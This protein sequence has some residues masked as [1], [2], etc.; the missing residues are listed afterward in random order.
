M[1]LN[2]RD[3]ETSIDTQLKNL[4][5]V[6][7]LNNPN[8]NVYKQ[9]VKTE[10]QKRALSGKRP[11]F[12]L[13]KDNST[14]PLIVIEAKRPNENIHKALEQGIDYANRIKAPIVF[15]TDGIFTKTLHVAKQKPLYLNKEELDDLIRQSI[16]INYIHD[17]EYNTLDK[18]VIQSREELIKIFGRINDKFREA[19]IESG[20]PRTIL[21]C[22]LLFLKIITELAGTNTLIKELPDWCTWDKIKEKRGEELRSFINGQAFNH[23][24]SAY[25]GDVLS[26][27]QQLVKPDILDTIVRELDDLH[28]SAT[29]TDI[30]GDAFEYF[31]RN[32]GGADT[33]FGEYFTPR[34]ITKVLIKLLNPQQGEKLYDPFC[35]T[36]GLLITGYKHIYERMARNEQNIKQLKESTIYG[37]ELSNMYRIAKMNMILAGDGH[38]NIV[39]QDSYLTPQASKY[40]VVA[41]NMPF[42]KKDKTEGAKLYG[43]NTKS[44]EV[45]G[46]LHCLNALSNAENARAGIIVPEGILF[47]GDKAYTDL[48][49]KITEQHSIETIVSLP[50]MVFAPYTNTKTDILIIKKHKN[51]NKNH[52]WYFDV[53]NDGFSLD[54]ARRKLDGSND[55]DNLLSEQD[56]KEEDKERLASLGFSVLYKDELKDN[57][58][59][60]KPKQDFSL[61]ANTQWPMVA[62]GDIC[63]IRK[64]KTITKVKA[65][66]NGSVQVIAGGTN[67]PYNHDI[68]NQEEPCITISASG[69][70]GYVWYHNYPIWAS[71]CWVLTS[72]QDVNIIFVYYALKHIQEDIYKLKRGATIPHVYESDLVHVTIPLPPLEEQEKIVK[73]LEAI[74][75]S[76]NN[77]KNLIQSLREQGGGYYQDYGKESSLVRLGDLEIEYIKGTAPKYGDSNIQVIKSG[78][79]R[80]LSG[81]NFSNEYFLD[82]S[83][84]TPKLLKEGDI[85][86]N[87]TGVGTAGRITYFTLDGNYV[88][89]S[90][91]TCIRLKEDSNVLPKYLHIALTN[92]YSRE[93]LEALCTGATGQIELNKD[94]ILNLEISLPIL[95]QQQAIVEQ[96]EIEET[97]INQTK[98][99]IEYLQDKI[100][101]LIATLW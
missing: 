58:Y 78:Q 84:K 36:G 101:N 77:A 29:N 93:N 96:F 73:Q 54:T 62:L 53:K 15:A 75:N 43:F 60:F 41:T 31:L 8:R 99:V 61:M 24:K 18:K 39:N 20:R 70:A 65:N 55:F 85:L 34:H 38:S 87:T 16:A 47:T 5:W 56:I 42:G 11:D 72:K 44:I 89:D 7:D 27:I 9:G 57:K 22:N 64:G 68:A 76:I 95:E 1:A 52:I 91:I 17:N 30:K 97:T 2:E 88:T 71:D 59:I 21:F 46:V 12:V 14:E 28:L 86:F 63:N 100:K 69:T 23:F 83:V 37:G 49:K 82:S 19:G 50:P 25:G 80:G 35:G 33:D 74:E 90:H 92:K 40:D 51:V 4:D 6:D 45:T 3:I 98:K 48:R 32:Y 13:Y 79:A 10:E 66:T 81:F 67:S 26:D 94:T